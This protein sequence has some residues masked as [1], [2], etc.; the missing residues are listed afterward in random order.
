MIQDV[1]LVDTKEHDVINRPSRLFILPKIGQWI[2][3]KIVN[4]L[5]DSNT[6]KTT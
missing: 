1:L 4:S 5:V 2:R 3:P 6:P